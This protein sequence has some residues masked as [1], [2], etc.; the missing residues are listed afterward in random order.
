VDIDGHYL[1]K[2]GIMTTWHNDF[3][4]GIWFAIFAAYNEDVSID[5]I[6][7]LNMTNGQEKERINGRK[8]KRPIRR[9]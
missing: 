5:K 3:E 6:I 7:I 2:H 8:F 1:P 4:E 9:R